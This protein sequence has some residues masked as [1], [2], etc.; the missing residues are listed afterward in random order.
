MGSGNPEI[1]VLGPV[2]NEAGN[3]NEF[4]SEIIEVLDSLGK[5]YE[6]VYV[7]DGSTD[8]SREM[9]ARIAEADKRVKVILFTRNFG[10]T[11]AVSAAIAAASGNVLITIDTDR[12]N[13]PRDIPEMLK[14]IEQGYDVISGWR[15]YRKDPYISRKLP[16]VFANWMISKIGGLYLHDYGCSLKAYRGDVLKNVRLYGEM[17]RFIPLYAK[18]VG[19]EIMEMPVNHR[20]RVAGKSKYGIGRTYKVVIDLLTVKFMGT[21]FT[22]PAYLF[23]SIGGILNIL[24]IMF[25]AYSL[26]EK[27]AKGVFVHRNP[28][29]MLAVFLSTLG[30][31]FI[32]MG[33]LAELVMRTYFESQNKQTYFIKTRYNLDDSELQKR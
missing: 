3:I 30:F 19:A 12:Q 16:S 20:P 5:S 29:I 32:L 10:Q 13:D 31:Q 21:F 22:K 33:L 18:Q 25:A 14:L 24:A 4:H 28:I 15:K 27:V 7:D 6:I 17:H 26:Y 8:G 1:S 2:Y 23:G 11:A 9:L